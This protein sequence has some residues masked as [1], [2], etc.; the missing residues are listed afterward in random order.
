MNQFFNNRR[1]LLKGLISAPV[2]SAPLVSA[3]LVSVPFFSTL[4]GL[5]F[6]AT[7]S[8]A[9]EKFILVI[10]RGAMDGLAAV[11]PYGD[12]SL[13]GLRDSLLVNENELNKLDSFFAL[14]P[15]FTGLYEMYN[16]AELLVHH[17]VASPYRERSHFDAQNVLEIGLNHPDPSMSGWLNRSL[18]FLTNSL[19]PNL[20]QSTS[21]MAIGQTVPHVLLGENPVGSWAPPVLPMPSDS[22]MD[23]I[24]QLY[25]RDKFLGAQ[26]DQALMANALMSNNSMSGRPGRG[27]NF[28]VL[29]NAAARFMR[30]EHGPQIAVVENSGWDTHANQGTTQGQL[31]RKFS[32]LDNGLT[33]LKNGLGNVWKD[34]IVL[35]VTEFGRTAAS[36]GTGGT[37]HGTAS[38][39]FMLGGDIPG[40]KVQTDWPGLN[41]GNLHDGRDLRATAELR[42]LFKTVLKNHLN[43]REEEIDSVILPA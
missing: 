2:V 8:S 24:K 11:Q 25:D 7:A 18:P 19:N 13:R 23:S 31:S 32:E 10:L 16:R 29:V 5:T 15:A 26:L 3:P 35:V 41:S 28:N 40:G 38:A 36:N 33:A 6:A 21:A 43:I 22:T 14:H 37:D 20:I 4:P 34:T 1:K 17:A 12:S 30:E 39:A 27:E 9:R 42:G